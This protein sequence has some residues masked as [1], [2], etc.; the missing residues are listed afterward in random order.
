MDLDELIDEVHCVHPEA[1]RNL[2]TSRLSQD[3]SSYVG[4]LAYLAYQ[5]MHKYTGLVGKQR[6]NWGGY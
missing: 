2:E 5:Q 6:L 3:Q 1:L 4:Q